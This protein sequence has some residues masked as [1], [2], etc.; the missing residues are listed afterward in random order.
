ML[1]IRMQRVGRKGHAQF[2]VIVQD[3][4]RSPATGKIIEYLGSYDPHT[5]EAKLEKES[6]ERYLKNGAQPSNRV[7]ILLQKEGFKLPKWV[8]IDKSGKRTTKNAEKLRKNQPKEKPTA[9]KE[10]TDEKE[11]V[12]DDVADAPIEEVEKELVEEIVEE[13]T[14]K[15]IEEEAAKIVAA[16]KAA[17]KTEAPKKDDSKDTEKTK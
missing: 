17:E 15:N 5:K 11:K 4:H 12:D 8:D 1:A 14:E 10:D 9:K 6:I 2:R 16:K 13:V 3:S 7:A